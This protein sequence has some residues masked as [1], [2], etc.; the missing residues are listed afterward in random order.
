[1]MPWKFL[2]LISTSFNQLLN[3]EK[4]FKQS[5]YKSVRKALI[6]LSAVVLRQSGLRSGTF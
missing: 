1:M 6:T 4:L 3:T 2:H 5:H